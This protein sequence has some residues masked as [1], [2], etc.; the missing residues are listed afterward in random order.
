MQASEVAVVVPRSLRLEP[1]LGSHS[2][3]MKMRVRSLPCRSKE[4]GK[5]KTL[6]RT[7]KGWGLLVSRT[8]KKPSSRPPLMIRLAGSVAVKMKVSTMNLSTF[9]TGKNAQCS[10]NAGNVARSLR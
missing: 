9:I 1:H 7:N 8:C 2:S 10:L 4:V 5:F 6:H 3:T